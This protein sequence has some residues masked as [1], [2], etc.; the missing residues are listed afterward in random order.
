M[1]EWHRNQYCIQIVKVDV[2]IRRQKYLW[3][4]PEGK[5]KIVNKIEFIESYKATEDKIL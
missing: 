1:S 4:E 3:H 2:E 5:Q